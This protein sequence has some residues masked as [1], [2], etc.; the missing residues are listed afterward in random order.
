[1]FSRGNHIIAAIRTLNFCEIPQAMNAVKVCCAKDMRIR[2][3]LL[4]PPPSPFHT[5]TH[6]PPTQH[7]LAQVFHQ[8]VYGLRE[9]T[10]RSSLVDD[11]I[12]E[13]YFFLAEL[14]D[15]RPD[16]NNYRPICQLVRTYPFLSTSS[17][18]HPPHPLTPTHTHTHTH[19]HT[20][21]HTYTH[22]LGSDKKWLP[23]ES[24][25]K[26]ES[27]TFLGPFLCISGFMDESVPLRSRYLSES[28]REED[29]ENLSN[30]IQQRLGICRVRE[31]RGRDEGGTVCLS[32]CLPVTRLVCL[33]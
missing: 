31:G 1:M 3:H 33:P 14:C 22:K 27:E 15:M 16:S 21:T 20:Y 23:K 17:Y 8:I 4:P 25:R 28:Y 12:C 5:H 32:A 11:K 13:G 10:S 26:A 9:A 30:T 19:I 6:L 18:P 24:G 7:P 2:D 29:A